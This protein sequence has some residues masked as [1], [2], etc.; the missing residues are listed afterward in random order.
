MRSFISL[1][2]SSCYRGL[3]TLRAFIDPNCESISEFLHPAYD[4]PIIEGM[5]SFVSNDS[6]PSFVKEEAFKVLS[7]TF[8]LAPKD[9]LMRFT[10]GL[11]PMYSSVIDHLTSG[12]AALSFDDSN[13]YGSCLESFAFCCK[14]VD[15]EVVRVV[16]IKLLHF[17]ISVF[18]SSSSRGKVDYSDPLTSFIHQACVRIARMMGTSYQPFLVNIIPPLLFHVCDEI[19]LSIDVDDDNSSGEAISIHKRGLGNVR[20][21][22]NNYLVVERETCCRVLM[23]YL[24]DIPQ[25]LWGY[26]PD[27]VA[28]VF[29]LTDQHAFIL[30]PN[31]MHLAAGAI[32]PES[33]RVFLVYSRTS[34]QFP[35]IDLSA[36]SHASFSSRT[37]SAADVSFYISDCGISFLLKNIKDSL[38]LPD[39][40]RR[41]F[42]K[43]DDYEKLNYAFDQIREIL[44][45]LHDHKAKVLPRPEGAG[46]E[47]VYNILRS[48]SL[49]IDL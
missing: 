28:S 44:L 12:Q 19:P 31:E 29:S 41:S 8:A 33:L 18:N 45:I 32:M 25:L 43:N 20:L 27:I 22:F 7:N 2:V 35:M 38:F 48:V 4:V 21:N 13:L 15:F 1:F 30:F 24:F 34:S 47:Q 11:I 9:S 42:I 14:S 37:M 36:L 49:K 6:F 17:A 3:S 5:L 39:S 10:S 40:S 26:T 16:A 46:F 23:Q